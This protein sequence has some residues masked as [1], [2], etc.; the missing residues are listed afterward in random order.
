MTPLVEAVQSELR[1]LATEIDRLDALAAEVFGLNRTDM[2]CLDVL[3]RA[4][5]QTP[6]ELA[7]ALDFT[8]GGITTVI[9]RLEQA[10]YVRRRADPGDRR[11]VIIEPTEL[12]A[13][14]EADIFGGLIHGAEAVAATYSAADLA[15]IRDFLSRSR[16]TIAAHADALLQR[17]R[18]PD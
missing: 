11:R 3:G 13:Q 16:A 18:A 6:T 14:R 17:S 2:R 4:G 12:V 7:H 10:G 9:D 15:T 5:A 8:T 1:A